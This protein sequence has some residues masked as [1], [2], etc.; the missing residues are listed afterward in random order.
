LRKTHKSFP[1]HFLLLIIKHICHE[2]LVIDSDVTKS[3]FTI[4]RNWYCK[5][6][7]WQTIIKK[8]WFSQK[9]WFSNFIDLDWFEL[10]IDNL[11]YHFQKKR[12]RLVFH[13]QYVI[14]TKE[15]KNNLKEMNC[16]GTA[17][18]F[19][20]WCIWKVQKAQLYD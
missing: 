9:H 1:H 20:K 4:S 14:C 13:F 10:K 5:F 12:K 2:P 17:L 15:T 19:A 6:N 7:P 11:A 16:N 3:I 18:Y 8:D